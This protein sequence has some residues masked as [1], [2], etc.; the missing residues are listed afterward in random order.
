MAKFRCVSLRMAEAFS[1]ICK[2]IRWDDKGVARNDFSFA[3]M[4]DG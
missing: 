4:T 1:K 2:M 3:E